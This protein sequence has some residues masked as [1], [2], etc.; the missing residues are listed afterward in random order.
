MKARGIFSVFKRGNS[1]S[2]SN[3]LAI[4]LLNNVS[5]LLEFVIHDHVSYYLNFK[6]NPYQPGFTKSVITN[7][8]NY[9]DFISPSVGPRQQAYAIYFNL[10]NALDLVPHS[11]L[12]QKLSVFG[13]S[14]GYVNWFRS[15]LS[16]R[17]S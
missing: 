4:S 6:I 1:A 11:L 15:N 2:V 5:I 17:Q 13:L 16:N 14:G 12:I 3:C 8:E 10:S 7:L 9:L